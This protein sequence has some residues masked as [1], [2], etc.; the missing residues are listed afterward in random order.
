MRYCLM[1]FIFYKKIKIEKVEPTER[2]S[3]GSHINNMN[4]DIVSQYNK[5]LMNV[6]LVF[7]YYLSFRRVTLSK[8]LN[9]WMHSKN[10]WIQNPAFIWFLR[11]SQE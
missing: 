10:V 7:N 2:T 1:F 4:V 6:N 3:T 5:N 8:W 11:K 9:H